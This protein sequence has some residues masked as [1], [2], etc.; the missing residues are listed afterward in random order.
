LKK[1]TPTITKAIQQDG[2]LVY[3][4]NLRNIKLP[5]FKNGKRVRNKIITEIAKIKADYTDEVSGG[6]TFEDKKGRNYVEAHHII[7]FNNENGPDITENLICLGP[8][9]HQLIHRGSTR[10]VRDFYHTTQTRGIITFE[11]FKNICT[12]YRCLTQEH[13]DILLAKGLISKSDSIELNKLIEI[14]G[15]DD[16][17]LKTIS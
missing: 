8:E 13:V 12:K 9:N 16:V 6:I 10:A 11:R 17:F 7:E 3:K 5:K 1:R 2:E 15:I 4:M 14:H